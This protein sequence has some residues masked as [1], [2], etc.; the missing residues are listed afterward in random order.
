LS[1]GKGGRSGAKT[2][3]LWDEEAMVIEKIWQFFLDPVANNLINYP[4]KEKTLQT[5][6]LQEDRK[7][8]SVSCS[9]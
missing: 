6:K 9:N 7:T 8:P 3:L 4:T 1:K 2:N 5:R